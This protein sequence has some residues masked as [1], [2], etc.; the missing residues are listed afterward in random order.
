MNLK[1][2]E[3]EFLKKHDVKADQIHDGQ[4]QSPTVRK[5]EAKRLGKTVVIGPPCEA[6]GHRLRT[7]AGHCVQ[8][9]PK[10]LAFQQRH[11]A[12]G[13]VYIA[14][15]LLGSVVKIGTASNLDQRHHQLRA[16]KYGGFSDWQILFHMHVEEGGKIEQRALEGLRK[17]NTPRLYIKDGIEQQSTEILNCNFSIALKALADSIGESQRD[18]VW[19][20]SNWQTYEFKK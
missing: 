13:Y 1:P 16:E 10:K 6:A 11:T 20:S 9:D 8:C 19:R 2:N 18:K 4:G 12:P 3:L 7:R 17:Y 5:A 15:S 14:G